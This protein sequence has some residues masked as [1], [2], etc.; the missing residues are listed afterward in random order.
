MNG[1]VCENGFKGDRY[2]SEK[3]VGFGLNVEG[4]IG[5]DGTHGYHDFTREC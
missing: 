3:R 5:S 4:R 2:V 1:L